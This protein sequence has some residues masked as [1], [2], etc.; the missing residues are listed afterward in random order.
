MERKKFLKQNSQNKWQKRGLEDNYFKLPFS[1]NILPKMLRIFA[2]NVE[3]AHFASVKFN[4]CFVVENLKIVQ[5]SKGLFLGMPSQPD[6]KGGYR[7]MAYP[8]TKEFREQLNTAVLQAYEAKLEQM[9]E[10]GSVGRASI[11]DQL[12]A[13][14]AAAE[15][16][17]AER[18][19]KEKPSRSAER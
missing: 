4:D 3:S 19:P 12:K 18:P 10:R 16:A 15:Q 6:G 11:S 13:G 14:K 1:Q 9:A 8:V 5:G 2:K 17:K 7:D